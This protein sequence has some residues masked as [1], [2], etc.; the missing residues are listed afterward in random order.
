MRYSVS[1][2]NA[3]AL[4]EASGAGAFLL[5]KAITTGRL[6]VLRGAWIYNSAS[7]VVV[8]LEDATSSATSIATNRRMQIKCASGFT[9]VVDIPLPGIKFATSCRAIL[10]AS[11][12]ATG[13]IAIG[14]A[15]GC[16]YE[17]A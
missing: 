2:A 6:L 1:G 13:V 12:A 11:Q 9:T 10:S 16:G 8:N 5:G 4:D 3:A 17:E 15:G 7:E 14:A